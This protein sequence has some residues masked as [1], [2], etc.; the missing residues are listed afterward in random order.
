M[1]RD[2]KEPFCAADKFKRFSVRLFNSVCQQ[3]L[4][5]RLRY[6]RPFW[7]LFSLPASFSLLNLHLILVI[8]DVF[9]LAQVAF[10]HI[11]VFSSP[12]WSS[13][14][15]HITSHQ[16]SDQAVQSAACSMWSIGIAFFSLS[17]ANSG[18][19]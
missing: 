10:A 4:R 11:L 19:L 5:T 2:Q 6:V 1:R 18:I 9:K 16:C 15:G 7:S 14:F 8:F 12:L 13:N 17:T 3:L